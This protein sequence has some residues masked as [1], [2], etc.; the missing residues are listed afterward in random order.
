VK[1]GLE[2]FVQ[3]GQSWWLSCMGRPRW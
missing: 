1:V 2:L 3:A